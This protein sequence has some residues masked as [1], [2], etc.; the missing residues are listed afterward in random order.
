MQGRRELLPRN[1]RSHRV[2]R[3]AGEARQVVRE[4][5]SE[6]RA[7][8]VPGQVQE[9]AELEYAHVGEALDIP[10]RDLDAR[11][12]ERCGAQ[13]I[14]ALICSVDVGDPGA[15][16]DHRCRRCARGGDACRVSQPSQEREEAG[17]ERLRAA[18]EFQARTRVEHQAVLRR[19]ADAG[20]VPVG[21]LRQQAQA[22]LLPVD[23]AVEVPEV[24]GDAA[25]GGEG[26]AGRDAGVACRDVHERHP[27][28]IHEHGGAVVLA[29]LRGVAAFE[30]LEAEVRQVY[31][32]PERRPMRR[33]FPFVPFARQ[34]GGGL[35][36]AFPEA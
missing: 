3:V 18:E 7:E 21:G 31:A 28:P 8:F 35:S 5:D 16:E 2:R 24:G 25:G 20:G 19:D 30:Y 26:R 11:A 32:V 10:R 1:N 34:S 6:T 27:L 23:V 36:H 17:D 4:R 15:S 22:S 33:G 14:E 13:C 12:F 29:R 9:L